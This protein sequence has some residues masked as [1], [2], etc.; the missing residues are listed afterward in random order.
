MIVPSGAV[1][2]TMGIHLQKIYKSCSVTSTDQVASKDM[3]TISKFAALVERG[4]QVATS[5]P[6]VRA[7][8][9]E[10]ARA[11]RAAGELPDANQLASAIIDAAV[12][13]LV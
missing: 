7:D 6:E 8:R 11:A 10:Q 12:E 5:L 4:R 1:D 13:G 2:K 9:V 3:V